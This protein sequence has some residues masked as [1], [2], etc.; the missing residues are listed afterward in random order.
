MIFIFAF[1][2]RVPKRQI[3]SGCLFRV[4][5]FARSINGVAVGV[6]SEDFKMYKLSK[7]I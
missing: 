1:V 7:L 6:E 2:C 4:K 3:L 5:E